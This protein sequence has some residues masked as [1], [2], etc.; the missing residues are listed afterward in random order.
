M[1]VSLLAMHLAEQI[2]L[3]RLCIARVV[4]PPDRERKLMPKAVLEFVVRIGELDGAN[5]FFSGGNQHAPQRRIGAGIADG[6]G[7]GAA[8]IFVRSHAQ[9]GGGALVQAAAGAV[10]G[11]V[12]GAGDGVAGL[13]IA[14]EL[15]HAAGVGV[16]ARR[17]A[18]H[19][20][21]RALQMERALAELRSQ[22][23]QRD[24]FV[25]MPLDVAADRLDHLR[26]LVAANRLRTATQAGAEAGFLGFIGTAEESNVF[27]ARTPRGAGGAAIDSG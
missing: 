15:V 9:L 18:K 13:Q 19:G 4:A 26:L 27:P 25:Q 12:H 1:N 24:R 14:L 5:T 10:A 11:V 20:L 2:A 16:G 23:A 21:E 6:R 22:A 8:T 17:D 7:D 3:S